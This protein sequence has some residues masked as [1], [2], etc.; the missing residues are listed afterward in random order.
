MARSTSERTE[1]CEIGADLSDMK[2][3]DEEAWKDEEVMFELYEERDYTYAEIGDLLG[4]S[5]STVATW[6]KRHQVDDLREELDVDIPNED[7]HRDEELMETLYV[8][9]ELSSTDIASLLECSTNTVVTW[10]ERH[11]IDTRSLAEGQSLAKGGRTGVYVYTN[12]QRGYERLKSHDDYVLH[13]QLLA[14]AYHGFET[15]CENQVHHKNGIHWDNR[16]DNL[17]PLPE[18]EHK[19]LHD[20][21]KMTWLDHLRAAEMYREGASSRQV[22]S[23]FD[24]SG[25][26]I[27]R[28]VKLVDEDLI[29]S[30]GVAN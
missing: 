10:L 23:A 16:P 21:Q 19:R 6:M 2:I 14:I 17:E 1:Q 22:A 11:G 8:E 18:E 9:E 30:P 26:T 20:I 29:R 3:P 4:C 24:V 12:I 28:S 27:L 15:V 7:P 25:N 5:D 13:H